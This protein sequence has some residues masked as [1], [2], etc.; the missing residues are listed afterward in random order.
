MTSLDTLND[1]RSL[2]VALEEDYDKFRKYNKTA[3]TRCRKHVLAISKLT[4]KLR[5][6]LLEEKKMMIKPKKEPKPKPSSKGRGRPK[7]SK[8][9]PKPIPTESDEV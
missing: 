1:L 7:G 6:E 8:T 2:M 9:K 4:T 3:G 5:K